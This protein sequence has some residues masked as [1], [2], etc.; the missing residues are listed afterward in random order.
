MSADGS[1]PAQRQAQMGALFELCD[2]AQRLQRDGRRKLQIELRAGKAIYGQAAAAGSNLRLASRFDLYP[3]AHAALERLNHAPQ[4]RS[5]G[6]PVL[7]QIGALPQRER[8][9]HA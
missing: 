3:Q 1:A 8:I 9:S 7:S 6:S 2:V 4:F 5:S